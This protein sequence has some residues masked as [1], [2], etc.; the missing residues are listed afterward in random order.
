MNKEE[1]MRT[2]RYYPN[3]FRDYATGMLHAGLII[4]LAVAA[5]VGAA[6]LL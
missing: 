5:M 1:T 3:F 6:A 4:T 2:A